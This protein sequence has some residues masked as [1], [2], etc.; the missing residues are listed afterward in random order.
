[1]KNET[2]IKNE[3]EITIELLVKVE[4]I[5]WFVKVKEK[6]TNLYTYT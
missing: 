2:Q 4:K 5:N 3:N 6:T 1:M